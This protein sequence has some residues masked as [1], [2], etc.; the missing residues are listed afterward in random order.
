MATDPEITDTG[1]QARFPAEQ[2]SAWKGT[3]DI[4]LEGIRYTWGHE[5]FWRGT[6]RVERGG[7][8]VATSGIAGTWSTRVT[9]EATDDVPLDHQ[10]FL[11]WM[12]FILNRRASSAATTAAVA[13]GAATA[14]SS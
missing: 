6:H 12:V 13:A 4:T 1:E 11:L 10:L 8:E 14:G 2:T 3:W 9:L 5:S 7:Q